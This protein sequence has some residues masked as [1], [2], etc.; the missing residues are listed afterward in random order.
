MWV[1]DARKDA[2][3]VWFPVVWE[4]KKDAS[5]IIDYDI[6]E[7]ITIDTSSV[8]NANNDTTTGM[9]TVIPWVNA[10][11]LIESTSIYKNVASKTASANAEWSVWFIINQWET[12][13]GQIRPLSIT[14]QEWAYTYTIGNYFNWYTETTNSCVVFPAAWVYMVTCTYNSTVNHIRRNY[15]IYLNLDIVA[16][17]QDDSYYSQ[18]GS[19]YPTYTFYVWVN[20]GDQLA[21]IYHIYCSAWWTGN[22]WWWSVAFEIIKLS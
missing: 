4:E 8:F 7:E 22:P 16:H 11:K 17:L 13:N 18:T 20:K 21:A 2:E 3:K 19:A 14:S 9:A 1:L 6:H 15:D 5:N 10:P 12:K